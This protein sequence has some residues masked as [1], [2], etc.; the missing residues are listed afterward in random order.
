MRK[1]GVK[2]HGNLKTF[3]TRALTLLL[4]WNITLTTI[5]KSCTKKALPIIC[6]DENCLKMKLLKH[7]K[8]CWK[9]NSFTNQLKTLEMIPK[10]DRY[11]E[12]V[13]CINNLIKHIRKNLIV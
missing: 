11:L 1:I 4:K 10:Y 7:C 3:W 8:K 6:L 5:Y 9:R 12:Y 2:V 13:Y